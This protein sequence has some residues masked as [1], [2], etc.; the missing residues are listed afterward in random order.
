MYHT[1]THAQAA[2]KR[3]KA[4]LASGFLALS[5][6]AAEYLDSS[7]PRPGKHSTATRRSP[8][9]REPLSPAQPAESLA[10]GQSALQTVCIRKREPSLF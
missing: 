6:L 7:A 9:L 3:A 1:Y 10:V 5:N 2:N 4:S 8:S